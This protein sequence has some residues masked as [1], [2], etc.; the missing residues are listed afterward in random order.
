MNEHNQNFG[1]HAGAKLE[2]YRFAEELRQRMTE[3]VDTV[4]VH[5]K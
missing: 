3:G 2:L 4:Q 5:D 1:M